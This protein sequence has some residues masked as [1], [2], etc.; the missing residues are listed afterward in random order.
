MAA[1]TRGR[2]GDQ[3]PSLPDPARCREV[4]LLRRDAPRLRSD[5]RLGAA[6]ALIDPNELGTSGPKW[7]LSTLLRT[8]AWPSILAPMSTAPARVEIR[9]RA[10]SD[11][12]PV[13]VG[14][15]IFLDAA[16]VL[17]TSS[18]S[19]WATPA[20]T[21]GEWLVLFVDREFG[22]TAVRLLVGV[23][24]LAFGMVGL[25]ALWRLKD[26]RRALS[27]DA[28]G[29]RFHPSLCPKPV[30]WSD[31]ESVTLAGSRPAKVEVRLKRRFWSLARPFTSSSVELNLW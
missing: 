16:F 2:R 9:T 3:Q 4:A 24:G 25:G 20:G 22:V 12:T 18:A 10:G 13:V 1:R 26:G 14:L 17:A 23:L 27:A 11:W 8:F 21:R 29:I 7:Q 6:A 19:D 31:V 5:R 15:V 30:P 28:D